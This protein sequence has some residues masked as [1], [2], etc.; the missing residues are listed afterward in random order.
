MSFGFS[1]STSKLNHGLDVHL[2]EDMMIAPWDSSSVFHEMILSGA[3]KLPELFLTLIWSN[4]SVN[5]PVIFA[6]AF[7]KATAASICN[8]YGPHQVYPSA[9]CLFKSIILGRYLDLESTVY[10]SRNETCGRRR[11]YWNP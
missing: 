10:K 8:H 7:G 1:P 5:D 3:L 6:S 2:S 11:C 4:A 9:G